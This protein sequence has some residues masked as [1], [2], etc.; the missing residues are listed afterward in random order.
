MTGYSIEPKSR[1]YGKGNGFLLFARKYKKQFFDI[2]LDSLKTTSKK[3]P[4]KISEFLGN[5]IADVVTKS[6]DDKIVKPETVEEIIILPEKEKK[7]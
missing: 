5:K 1:K 7:Y 3:A 6:N 2:G 4:H